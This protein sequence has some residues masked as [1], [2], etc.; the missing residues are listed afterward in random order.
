MRG[1]DDHPFTIFVVL[2][3]SFGCVPELIDPFS[4]GQRNA[5]LKFRDPSVA[6]LCFRG[7]MNGPTHH[8]Q[9]T[10]SG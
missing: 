6:D 3:K 1:K 8:A 4:W 9:R 5:T 10:Q 2:R 7:M